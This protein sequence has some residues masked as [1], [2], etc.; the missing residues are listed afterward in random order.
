M[1]PEW[2][3]GLNKNT[4]SKLVE[5]MALGTS[6]DEDKKANCLLDNG[7]KYVNWKVVKIESRLNKTVN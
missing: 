6:L 3:E 2:W 7:S 4:Q 1:K 5:R